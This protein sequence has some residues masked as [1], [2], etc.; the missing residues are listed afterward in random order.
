MRSTIGALNKLLQ[1]LGKPYSSLSTRQ[2]NLLTM[3]TKSV[4]LDKQSEVILASKTVGWHKLLSIHTY[5]HTYI[6]IYIYIYILKVRADLNR[7]SMEGH[8][9]SVT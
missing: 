9:N 7:I 3:L 2:I 6:H 8:E 5:I 4:Q 1:A